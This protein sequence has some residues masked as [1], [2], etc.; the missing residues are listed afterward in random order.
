MCVRVHIR[1]TEADPES[2]DPHTPV[3]PLLAARGTRIV[4]PTAQRHQVRLLEPQV[5]PLS[6]LGDMMHV[7]C[8]N[9]PV[10]FLK[11]IHTERMPS[12]V[13][14]T[15]LSPMPIIPAFTRRIAPILAL[16]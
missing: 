16:F 1:S 13:C 11:A 4:M 8:R 2:F 15:E 3:R 5:R 9:S 6:Q 7:G 10:V 12:Q 14:I